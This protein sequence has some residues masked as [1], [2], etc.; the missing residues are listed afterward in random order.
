MTARAC[1]PGR[2]RRLC[3]TS[4]LRAL[5]AAGPSLWWCGAP[6]ARAP[7]RRAAVRVHEPRAAQVMAGGALDLTTVRDDPN[8]GAVLFVGCESA[9]GCAGVCVASRAHV[10]GGWRVRGA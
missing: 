6:A 4:Q 2:R 10:R 1:C 5:A 7:G 9:H 8:V 3:A